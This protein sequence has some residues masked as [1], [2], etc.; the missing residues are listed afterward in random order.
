[1]T[2]GIKECVFMAV[3]INVIMHFSDY[4][5]FGSSFVKYSCYIYVYLSVGTQEIDNYRT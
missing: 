2:F 4:I 1:M 3:K 5:A